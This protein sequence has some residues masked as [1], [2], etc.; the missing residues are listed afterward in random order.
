MLLTLYCWLS[1]ILTFSKASSQAGGAAVS[2]LLHI[3]RVNVISVT[4]VSRE[5]RAGQP[6]T[7]GLR[8]DVGMIDR[9]S[10]TNKGRA[11]NKL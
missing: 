1:N 11:V 8:P 7:A 2:S 6:C 9:P 5:A 10:V 4:R 3:H